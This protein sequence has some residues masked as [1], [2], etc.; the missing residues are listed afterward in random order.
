MLR[1]KFVGGRFKVDQVRLIRLDWF[2]CRIW[3]N[4]CGWWPLVGLF[5]HRYILF[6]E[7]IFLLSAVLICS[8][9]IILLFLRL[10]IVV[11]DGLIGR[12]L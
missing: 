9:K 3:I 2:S 5:V 8:K 7:R 6:H 1:K 11:I 4:H 12:I 10:L